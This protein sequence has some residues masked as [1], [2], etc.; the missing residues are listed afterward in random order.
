VAQKERIVV[1][2]APEHSQTLRYAESLLAEEGAPEHGRR[3]QALRRIIDEWATVASV[4]GSDPVALT[5]SDLIRAGRMCGRTSARLSDGM[6]MLLATDATDTDGLA[7]RIADLQAR[8]VTHLQEL[9]EMDE[10]VERLTAMRDP[11]RAQREARAPALTPMPTSPTVDAPAPLPSS[12]VAAWARLVPEHLPPAPEG[13]SPEAWT[14][15]CS[16]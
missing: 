2:L 5:L 9:R 16:Q 6:L 14:R 8:L 10:A 3:T 1:D 7:R 12:T 13:W 4:A 15:H 11:L